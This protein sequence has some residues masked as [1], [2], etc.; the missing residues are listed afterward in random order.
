MH[1]SAFDQLISDWKKA[2]LMA[3]SWVRLHKLATLEKSLVRRKLGALTAP[4]YQQ[5][6]TILPQL[7]NA[8]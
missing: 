7:W 4:D 5:I 2:G 6:A 8:W 1:Q 3:P